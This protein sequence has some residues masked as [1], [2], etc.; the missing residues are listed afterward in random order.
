[1]L[2]TLPPF[3]YRKVISLRE[4]LAF[5]EKRGKVYPYAGGTDLL[6]ALKNG[7]AKPQVL[8]DVKALPELGS[9]RQQN[10]W[11][12][13]GAAVS[14]RA[15]ARSALIRERYS[16][17]A[18]AL[19]ILGSTQIANRAT[20]G[21]NLCN[22]SP[23][24]DSAPPLLALDARVRLAGLKGNRDLP[25]AEFFLGPNKTALKRELLTEILIP[26]AP[27][28][29]RGLFS[30]LGSRSAPED[31]A[32]V[33]VAAFVVPDRAGNR[34]Q[35]ARI[36]LGAVGP[37]PMRARYAEEALVGQPISGQSIRDASRV[38]AEK[39]AQP[40]SDIRASAGYRRAMVEVLLTRALEHLASEI[41]QGAAR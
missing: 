30:K 32:I 24:A 21:G 5:M 29:G 26:P 28:P 38:A 19:K 16:V 33:S 17:L 1:M 7:E 3:E 40:I 36:A 18:Q 9:V 41:V 37:A 12:S 23:A 15:L 14:V 39:D 10:G 13:L 27:A 25:L 35:E 34:W 6:V 31:I 22:A 2:G 8:L 11:I 20:L 4:A